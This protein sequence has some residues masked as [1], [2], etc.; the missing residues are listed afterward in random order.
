[1]PVLE[2]KDIVFSYPN[3]R[4]ILN[5]VSFRFEQNLVHGLVGG[6]GVG[7]T[8]FFKLLLNHLAPSSGKIMLGPL[9]HRNNRIEYQQQLV[10]SNDEPHYPP[11]FTGREWLAFVLGAYHKS[12][13]A[14]KLAHLVQ[15]FDFKEI[16]ILT[17]EY[18]HGMNK[19][20]S[21]IVNFMVDVD[22]LLF[23]ESMAGIDPFTLR[24]IYQFI[25]SIR[26]EKV[27][28]IS[29]HSRELIE[30]CADRIIFFD[31]GRF[32]LVD[33][34]DEIFKMKGSTTTTRK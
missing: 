1:M 24:N 28:I 30:S 25:R 20:L 29:S 16:D 11:Y 34:Y 4:K 12:I 9:H 15:I 23:D 2:V 14:Q 13:D 26:K 33:R 6:N 19:K 21:M 7:K 17:S 5:Q 27:I 18:S 22:C 10:F 8:T 32:L 3:S 31:N